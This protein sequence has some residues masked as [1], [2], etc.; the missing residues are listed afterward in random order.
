MND[1]PQATVRYTRCPVPSATGV[2]LATGAF[3]ALNA[4]RRYGFRDIAELGEAGASAH[5]THAIDYFFREGGGSPPIWARANGA[6]SRLL[7]VTFM[8]E[9]LGVYVRADDPV[10]SVADLRG[11]RI[12]LP[13]W[14]ALV[15]DFW[16]A[17]AEKGYASALA[18]HGLSERD[19]ESVD[20]VET[21]VAKVLPAD[22]D[23]TREPGPGR[24]HGYRQQL[25]A[26]LAGRVDALFGK[27]AEAVRLEQE[28]GGAIRLL[29]DLRRSPAIDDR[30][31]NSSPRL[32]TVSAPLLRDHPEAAVRYLQ[33]LL[34]AATWARA[35]PDAT[36]TIIGRECAIAA[37]DVPHAF[38]PAFADK[39]APSLAPELLATVAT[40]K[41]FL[42]ARGYLAGDVDLHDWIDPAPLAE[43]L[44]RERAAVPGAR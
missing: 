16:R 43:A 18:L 1:A 20:I 3:D 34:R 13:R 37:A 2:A 41:N 38:E 30:V 44:R 29:D 12:A 27:G 33:G 24:P 23:G 26:L 31:N 28:A 6:A 32:V 17:A 9:L 5:Y 22:R 35:H 11:R 19:V 42:L 15:F 4:D 10:A 7:G 8:D 36:A 40:M 39:L 25:A 21:G 14:P